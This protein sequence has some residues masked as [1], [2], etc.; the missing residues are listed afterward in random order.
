MSVQSKLQKSLL[1]LSDL[2]KHTWTQPKHDWCIYCLLHFCRSTNNPFLSVEICGLK[3]NDEIWQVWFTLRVSSFI[4]L[5]TLRSII[6]CF[7]LICFYSFT[8]HFS[9][10]WNSNLECFCPHWTKMCVNESSERMEGVR[11][12]G[13]WR[14]LPPLHHLLTPPVIPPSQGEGGG[15][16]SSV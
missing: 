3:K 10:L 7:H 8:L 2:I 11:V 9:S 13:R 14:L 6:I 15:T 1:K 5:V 12:H 4:S 16:D